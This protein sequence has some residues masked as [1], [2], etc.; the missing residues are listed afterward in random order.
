MTRARHRFAVAAAAVVLGL[1]PAPVMAADDCLDHPGAVDKPIRAITLK[2]RW[3]SL[4]DVQYPVAS[5]SPYSAEAASAILNAV[6]QRLAGENQ[7]E[8]QARGYVGVRYISICPLTSGDGVEVRVEATEVRVPLGNPLTG[9]LP[10]A[11]SNLPSSLSGTPPVLPLLNPEIGLTSDS[12]IG[13][14]QTLKLETDLL[15]MGDVIRGEA[16][17][18]PTWT[19]PLA[20]EGRR[21]LNEDTYDA[22]ARLAIGHDAPLRFLQHFDVHAELLTSQAPQG[23]TVLRQNGVRAGAGFRLKPSRLFRQVTLVSDAAF[24]DQRRGTEAIERTEETA[25]HLFGVADLT[26]GLG[27]LRWATLVETSSVHDA[28]AYQ[29]VSTR[30]GWNGQV[31]LSKTGNQ[32]IGVEL[33][34][35]AG[36]IWGE[37]PTY[38]HY[39]A[40]NNGID[41]LFKPPDATELRRALLVPS[42]RSFGQSG[43]QT[44]LGGARSYWNLHLNVALPIAAFSMALIPREETDTGVLLNEMVYRNGTRSAESFLASYYENVEHMPADQAASRAAA[45][46]RRIEPALDFITHRANLYSVKPLLMYDAARLSP[47]DGLP[48]RTFQALG[49]GVQ[50]TIVVARMEAGYLWTLDR[51]AG[52]SRGNFVFRL[53]FDNIF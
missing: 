31:P 38:A 35:G 5:G 33:E 25:F 19:M 17:E 42:L 40:G 1:A 4:G 22:M 30:L 49:T 6:R 51:Q 27:P 20:V 29:R 39:F 43:A 2:S 26:T 34:A 3:N 52:D 41:F 36:G 8:A 9:V 53:I 47:G 45:E 13:V 14:A 32:T 28:G 48:G 12:G 50:L 10:G 7:S 37:A 16:P 11:R 18:A 15:S 23:D 24:A 46:I 44:A 21:G